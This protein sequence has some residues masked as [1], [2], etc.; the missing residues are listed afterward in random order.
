MSRFAIDVKHGFKALRRGRGVTGLAVLAFALGIGVT[1]AVFSLFYGILLKPLPY[2]DPDA[3]T[4]VYDTQP[5]CATCPA[6]FPKYVDWKTR[7]TV[8]AGLG[9]SSTGIQVITG[10]GD[11]ERVSSVRATASLVNDVFRVPAQI[12]RWFTEDEDEPGGPKVVVLSHGYWQR[13][14][15]G[16]LG[17]IG[18]K[19]TINGEPHEVVGVMPETF[20]HRRGEI[21]VPVQIA[22]DASQRG[23]HF[24]LT[25]GRLKPGVTVERART[26]MKAFGDALAQE[27]GYNHGIDVVSLYRATVGSVEGPLRML[28]GAVSL[29]LLIASA[30]VANLL[31]ASGL[32]RRRELAV[33]SALGATRWDLAR[34]ITIESVILALAGGALG[35]LLAQWATTTFVTMAGTILPRSQFISIDGWVLGFA[36]ALSLFTGVFCGLWPVI[37]LKSRALA[38]AVREGDLRSGA[39]GAGRRFGNGLVVAEIAVA[40]SLLVGAGLLMKSLLN[41]E[42]RDTGFSV[43]RIVAFDLAPTGSRYKENAVV[44]AF[45]RDLIP[46]LRS[47]GGVESVGVTSHLPM[48]QFGW[49]GEVTLEGG[50]PWEANAAPLIENRWVGGDYFQTM[51]IELLQGRLFNDTDRKG[52]PAAALISARTAEKFWPGQ[53]PIGRRFAKGTPGPNSTWYHVVGVVRDVRSYGLQS[54][55]PYE[56]YVPIEQE[57]FGAMTVVLRTSSEDPTVVMEPARQVVR[58]LDAQL[59]VARVQTMRTVVADSVNQPRLISALTTLFGALAGVLAAVG[60]YGVMSYNVRRERREFGIR[61]A[62]GAEPGKVRRLIVLRGLTLG[63]IGV[64]LGLLM[65][66]GLTRL[67][68]SLLTDVKATDPVVFTAAGALL[69]AVA[70]TAVL[71]PALQASRTDPMIVLR[72]E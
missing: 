3:L 34:Q 9:G 6:S 55:S 19:L 63:G 17:I 23:S 14:F 30:N 37:R 47:I 24:L 58:S 42:G 44:D 53:D 66:I 71:I 41:L 65:A 7:N 40:F 48:Y 8:Y 49:N 39:D 59:P 46:K 43:D 11:P 72:S 33:R 45:Y 25:Y 5:A 36:A 56:M 16:D 67:M 52:A 1:T 10:V 2:P 54:N 32:S 51:G 4:L 68:E 22:Y 31:L 64:G 13:R 26:E 50:S 62:L 15:A 38:Q 12:G 20:V 21:F 69:L 70:I 18:R 28:M 35:L 61:L 57:T 29:V 27:Y 60:V